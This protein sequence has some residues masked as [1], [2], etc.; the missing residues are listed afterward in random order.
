MKKQMS[1]EKRS[2]IEV[3]KSFS[4]IDLNGTKKNFISEVFVKAKKPIDRYVIT[5]ATQDDLDNEKLKFF[6]C[7]ENGEFK[8]RFSFKENRPLNHYLVIK[9]RADDN[10][11]SPVIC[12]VLVKLQEIEVSELPPVPPQIPQT[13]QAPQIQV[14][15]IPQTQ[16]QVDQNQKNELYYKALLE[17]SGSGMNSWY[18]IGIICIVLFLT[19]ILNKKM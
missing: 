16:A 1:Q 4:L 7:D 8:T 10:N 14:P 13:P 18:I 19:I 2:V 5:I 12:D 11:V 15:Q 9:K 17:N 6:N 3:N